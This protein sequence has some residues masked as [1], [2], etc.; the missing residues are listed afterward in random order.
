ML[1]LPGWV[2]T[3]KEPTALGQDAFLSTPDTMRKRASLT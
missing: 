3:L 1:R 2:E